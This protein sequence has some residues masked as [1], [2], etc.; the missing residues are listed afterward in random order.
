[1]VQRAKSSRRLRESM[2]DVIWGIRYVSAP[3]RL[4]ESLFG[5]IWV[6][7]EVN[8]DVYVKVC[9]TLRC[10][11]GFNLAFWRLHESMSEVM[12]V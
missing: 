12:G 1:M 3:R 2:S 9:L 7:A 10:N 5:V 6:V 11:L 8:I 4:H